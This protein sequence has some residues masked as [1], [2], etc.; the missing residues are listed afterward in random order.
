MDQTEV[1]APRSDHRSKGRN[2]LPHRHRM[3]V[4]PLAGKGRNH[5]DHHTCSTIIGISSF[6]VHSIEP[7]ST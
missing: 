7:Q 3:T 4:V 1:Q 2:R 6:L 5:L